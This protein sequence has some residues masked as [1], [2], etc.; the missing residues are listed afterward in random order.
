[1]FEISEIIKKRSLEV[2]E[3]QS[4]AEYWLSSPVLVLGGKTPLEVLQTPG[5]EAKILTILG[6]IEY[7]VYS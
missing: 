5:G 6:R 1:M 4:A 3:S 2:F 7:G